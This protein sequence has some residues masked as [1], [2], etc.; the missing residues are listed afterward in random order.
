MLGEITGFS[1]LSLQPTAGAGA[2]D[3]VPYT[4]RQDVRVEAGWRAVFH[5]DSPLGREPS[6][7]QF[8]VCD[9]EVGSAGAVERCALPVVVAHAAAGR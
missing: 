7:G 2:P 3:Y 5:L 9:I 8:F 6:Y 1:A 4:S